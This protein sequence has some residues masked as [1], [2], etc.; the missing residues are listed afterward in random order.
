MLNFVVCEDEVEFQ[1]QYKREIDNFMMNYDDDYNIHIFNDYD[2]KWEEFVQNDETYKVYILDVVT[3]N[4][5]GIDAGRKIREQYQDYSSMIIII[6]SHTE[7]RFDALSKRL[8]LVEFINKLDNCKERLRHALFACM[9][10]YNKR[11][12][13]L[14]YEYQKVSYNISHQEIVKIV[15]EPDSKRC[16][17]STKIKDSY[18]LDSLS[19]LEKKLGKQFVKCNRSTL[20]NLDQVRSYDIKSNILELKTGE[21]IT[22]TARHKRRIIYNYVRGIY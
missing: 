7:Q 22:N 8:M 5:S 17:I 10:N 13:A 1:K 20:I 9:N 12:N 21:I 2:D 14:K 6:S 4:G 11:P 16:V 15:R 18:T 3:K 19:K